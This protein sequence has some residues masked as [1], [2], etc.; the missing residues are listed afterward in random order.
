MRDNCCLVY[1][2]Q[3]DE[4]MAAGDEED[5]LLVATAYNTPSKSSMHEGPGDQ[6]IKA[7]R[8]F[9]IQTNGDVDRLT[10]PGQDAAA[11]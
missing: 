4:E 8:Q 9:K 5:N 7:V 1:V 2:N 10:I 11:V 3:S 6:S